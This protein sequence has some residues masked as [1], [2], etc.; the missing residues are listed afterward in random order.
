MNSSRFP[1]ER[2][3]PAALTPQ[4]GEG[5]GGPLRGRRSARFYAGVLILSLAAILLLGGGVLL[6]YVSTPRFAAL[7]RERVVAALEDTTGGRVELRAFRWSFSHLAVEADNLTIHGSENAK[8]TP[9]LHIDRVYVR[10]R[11]LSFFTPKIALDYL[12]ADHPTFHF[13]VYSDGSTNQPKPRAKRASSSSPIAAIFDLQIRR[14]V[15][16][17]GVVLLNQRAFPFDFDAQNLAAGLNY[18]VVPDR[19]AGTLQIGS[20]TFRPGGSAPLFGAIS[21]P[22]RGAISMTGDLEHN[23]AVVERLR[24]TLPQSSIDISGILVDFANPRWELSANGSIALKEISAITGVDGLR[25]GSASVTLTGKGGGGGG[26]SIGGDVHVLNGDFETSYLA[27]SGINASA[28]LHVTP[29]ELAFS[30]VHTKLPEGGSVDA[31]LR[32]LHWEQ[33][34]APSSFGATQSAGTGPGSGLG[35]RPGAKP[36]KPVASIRAMVHGVRL[37][38]ILRMVAIRRFQDLGFDTAADGGVSVDWTDSGEDL[39]VAAKMRLTAPQGVAP[40]EF[41]VDGSVDAMYFQRSGQVRIKQLEA[42]TLSTEVQATGSLGVYPVTQNSALQVNLKTTSLGDFD[43]SLADLGLSFRGETGA[44][45]I[46]VKL[47]GLAEFSGSVNGSLLNPDVR[48]HITALH[49]ATELRL[50][51]VPH[52]NAREPNSGEEIQSV[53]WDRLDLTGE[54]S[55]SRIVIQEA[56]LTAGKAQ[57]DLHGQ[58]E[59]TRLSARRWA[60]DRAS[61]IQAS[62]HIQNSPLE[63]LLALAGQSAPVS[64]TVNLQGQIAGNAGSPTGGANF[65]VQG[66]A[67]WSEP[68]RRAS[69]EMTFA[70]GML[71]LVR[72]TLLKDGG[73]IIANGR[74]SLENREFLANLDGTHFELARIHGLQSRAV[75][76]AGDLKFDAH[77]SGTFDAPSIL[78]GVH[79]SGLTVLSQPVGALEAVAHTVGRDVFFTARSTLTSAL[80]DLSGKTRLEGDYPTSAKLSMSGLDIDPIF[81]I[82]NVRNVTG[83]STIDGLVTVA[84]PARDPRMFNGDA[85]ISHFAVTLQGITLTGQGPLRASIADGR[86]NVQQAHITGQDTDMAVSGSAGLK[87]DGSLDLM[88]RGAINMKLAETFDT[89]I[90]AAGRADFNIGAKGTVMQPVLTGAVQLRKVSLALNDL[91]NGLSDL[92]GTLIFDQDRLDVRDLVATTGGGQLKVSGFIT[93]QRGIYGD[94]SATGKDIRVRYSGLSATADTTLRL[95]GTEANLLLS[96]NVLITRFIAGPN[97]D[98]AVLAGPSSPSTPPNPNSASSHV[99]LD[100]HV[101]SSPQ[102]EFQNSYAQLAGSVDLRIRGTIAQPSVLGRIDITEG[103]ATFAGTPYQLQRGEIDF[104]NPVRIDPLIDLDATTRVEEYDVTIGLHGNLSHLTPTF[105]SDPPLAQA[106]VVS[107]LALGRTQ[108]QQQLYVQ[109]QDQSGANSTTNALLGGALNAAVSNRVQKLFGVGSVKIDPTY[110]GNLGNSTARVTVTQNLSRNIQLTY[111]TN[112]NATAEQLIQAQID[113]TD[114]LSILAVRDEIGVFSMVLRIHQR[115]R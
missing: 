71:N 93:Y 26:F 80:F 30:G 28:Q 51:A 33:A 83:R 62:L 46:P 5:P 35:P 47:H 107:L 81:K 32:F 91:P 70:G 114:S 7:V 39:T 9:Y 55:P 96:G 42:H 43:R 84:G 27:A 69:G 77:A 102:L 86:L 17:D 6:F 72:L 74:Y 38:V 24:L 23:R 56:A 113:L 22:L 85:E 1:P 18:L 105:R 61:E 110:L 98:F 79:L 99:R 20:L 103:S 111:A 68:Y 15:V 52:A 21:A 19:Y 92:N 40:H 94:L 109:E 89:D 100:V 60:Y 41:P 75:P 45:A 8:E 3:P 58:V 82:F 97:L 90:T 36:L 67:L 31:A 64:G 11:I 16:K 37:P 10:V 34:A 73:E 4:P 54:Y 66:G 2:R 50:P 13:I 112:V 106:D 59:A 12:E 76:V 108:Q 101:A 88:A 44:S 104:A 87:R 115:A 57:I 14:T 53:D 48:G 78:L 95:Q 25:A 63:S 65:T 29:D 49:F